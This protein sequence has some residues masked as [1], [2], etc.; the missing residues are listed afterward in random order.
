MLYNRS[1]S[2]NDRSGVMKTMCARF[3]NNEHQASFGRQFSCAN[4]SIEISADV[5]KVTSVFYAVLSVIIS[6]VVRIRRLLFRNTGYA[7]AFS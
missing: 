3:M 5:G 6:A 7:N 1:I 4:N 2:I